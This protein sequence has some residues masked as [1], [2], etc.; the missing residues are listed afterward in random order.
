[1]EFS[2]FQETRRGGRKVNQDRVGYIYT[3]DALFVVVAD[4]MGGHVGGEIAAHI[5]VRLLLERFEQEAKPVLASPVLFLQNAFKAAHAALGDYAQRF[6]LVDTPRTTCVACVIQD[7]AAYWAHA[8]DSRLYHVRRGALQTRT[9]DHS[10]V[11]YLLDNGVISAVEAGRHPDRNKV[12]SCLGGAFEPTVDFSPRVP[13]LGNDVLVL[14]TDGLWSSYT[15]GELVSRM[16]QSELGK[17]TTELLNDAE[18]RSGV[19]CDNLSVIAIRWAGSHG[20]WSDTVTTTHTETLA[21][22]EFSTQMDRTITLV[23]PAT[24]RRVLSDAEIELA[25]KEIQDTLNRHG[26]K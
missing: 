11:Q 18:K 4:G 19:D 20:E 8:G 15:D 1:M 26:S 23:E 12:F 9:R 5:T 3:R 24:G 14:C 13:L 21:M 6:R 17:A 22:G 16:A 10:K 7:D 2:I 25:I